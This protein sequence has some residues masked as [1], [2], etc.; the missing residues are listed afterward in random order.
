MVASQSYRNPALI[1]KIA[2]SIDN[3]SGGRLNFGVGA[4]WKEVEYK[5][6]GYQFPSPNI[7]I[8]QLNDALEIAK[9]MWTTERATYEGKYYSVVNAI[10]SPKPVQKPH[11][12]IWIGG[13]GSFILK[14][15]ARHADAINFAWTIPIEQF[16]AKLTEFRGY[17]EAR[18]RDYAGIRKSAGLMITMAKDDDTLKAKLKEREANSNTPYMRY[19]AKQPTNL[20]GT[21]EQ[22][23]ERIKDYLGLGVDHFII[24]FHFGE[25]VE[26]MRL[27]TEKVKPY[28]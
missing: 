6:Y 19:L 20:I 7:R 1:A 8:R 22:V 26:G 13:T 23:A 21:T 17:C 4:G 12:P 18:G 11:P 27:F 25:E 10:S 24:R 5:A 3:I 2:A 16:R 9:R 15:A 14:I 28:L